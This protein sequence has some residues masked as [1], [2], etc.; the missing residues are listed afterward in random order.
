MGDEG[1]EE[2]TKV[3]SYQCQ[4]KEQ[5][6]TKITVLPVPDGRGSGKALKHYRLPVPTEQRDEGCGGRGKWQRREGKGG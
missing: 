5:K 2:G 4:V 1:G 3:T 6:G